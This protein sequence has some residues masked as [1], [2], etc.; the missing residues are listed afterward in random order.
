MIDALARRDLLA[1][2]SL[3]ALL[4]FQIKD[5]DMKQRAINPTDAS[6]A[7][8][9]EVTDVRR[10]VFVSGQVPED[11]K[12]RVPETFRDQARLAWANVAAQLREAQMTVRN[13]VKMTIFLSDRKYRGEAYEVRHEVLGDHCPA[14]TII[15]CGIY[16]EEWLLEIEAIAAA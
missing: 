2:L 11:D 3:A 12:D 9:V 4:P 1:G 6:Y 8:A 5:P 16:R 14:M 7:Q 10:L 13:I 15:I